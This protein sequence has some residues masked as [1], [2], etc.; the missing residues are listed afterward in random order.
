LARERNA[1]FYPTELLPA[2]RTLDAPSTSGKTALLDLP[3]EMLANMLQQLDLYGLVHIAAT[4]KNLCHGDGGLETVELPTNSLVITALRDLVFPGGE[5]LPRTRPFGCSESW[6]AYPVRRARQRRCWEAPSI[7]AGEE[8]TLF[9]DAAGRLLACGKGAAAGHGDEDAIHSAPI[10]MAAMAAVR[11]R[12]VAAGRGFSLALAFDGRVYSWGTN[13]DGELGHGDRRARPAP[14]LVEGLE[15][16]HGIAA[17]HSHSLAVTQSGVVFR[18]GSELF[19]KEDWLRPL[20]VEGFGDA[21]VRRVYAG[22]YTFFAIGEEGELFSW[23]WNN[24]RCLGHGSYDDQLSPKRVEA[25]RGVR[26]SSFAV[27][28]EHV[29]ALAEDGLVHAWGAGTRRAVLGKA[30]VKRQL[31]P[32]IVKALRGVRINSIAAGKGRSYAVADTGELWAWGYDGKR[33]APLG[34]C[35]R[36]S[37]PVPKPIQSLQGIMVDSVAVGDHQ[38]IAIA[39]DGNV[40]AWGDE[41]A[42]EWGALGLGLSVSDA[43]EL[44]PTPHRVSGLRVTCGM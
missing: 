36:L 14:T 4:C 9:V 1:D 15:G 38:T 11:V 39:A 22:I 27:G 28:S 40:Y 41:H 2:M 23:G 37:C 18:W 35:D 43:G 33:D 5:V 26:V 10:P 29:L 7:A 17:N 16:V 19:E 34:H 44:V 31:R 30:R 42:A 13:A 24:Y 8:H 20:I 6:V 32:M 12:S 25:L 21:R 3:L